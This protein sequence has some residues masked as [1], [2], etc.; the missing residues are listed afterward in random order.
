M[1]KNYK[2]DELPKHIQNMILEVKEWTE[3]ANELDVEFKK[4]LGVVDFIKGKI[5]EEVAKL[6]A[7]EP[8]EAVVK[9][10]IVTEPV[11][12]K[13]NTDAENKTV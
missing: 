2:F 4:A 10:F 7:S 11:Q 13:E 6:E 12:E 8:I 1:P 3:K 5:Q 9:P